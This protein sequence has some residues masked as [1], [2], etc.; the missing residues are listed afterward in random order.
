MIVNSFNRYANC[1][2]PLSVL[3]SFFAQLVMQ[4]PIKNRFI[5]RDTAL[6]R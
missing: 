1:P 5:V 2:L 6:S 4:Q 3:N